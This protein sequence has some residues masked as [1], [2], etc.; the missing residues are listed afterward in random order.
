MRL[1][2]NDKKALKKHT[3]NL[4]NL[5][6]KF[7]NKQLVF[8]CIGTDRCT[9][10]ALGPIVGS[11]LLD[12]G[13][14][15]PGVVIGN[16]EYPVHAENLSRT[17]EYIQYHHPEACIIAIDAAL[18]REKSIETVDIVPEQLHP[19][20]ALNCSLPAVGDISIIANVNVGGYMEFDVLR[21]TRLY[22]IMRM[23]NF[24]V[25]VV[26]RTVSNHTGKQTDNTAMS[27]LKTAKG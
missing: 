7:Q 3:N 9:G 6:N 5:L 14:T 17:V 25:N 23:S 20:A 11:M 12:I 27:V 15:F 10:E 21:S 19:G 1:H 16:L 24:I 18:G 4:T 8:L 2:I 13:P 26:T 22:R